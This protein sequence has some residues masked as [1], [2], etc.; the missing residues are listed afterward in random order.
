M[1]MRNGHARRRTRG[2][3]APR[4]GRGREVAGADRGGHAWYWLGMLQEKQ[5]RKAEAK[6]S[7]TNANRLMPGDKNI[8]EALKRVR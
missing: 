6:Q 7:F 1:R 2:H 5:G 4:L 8:T 3:G